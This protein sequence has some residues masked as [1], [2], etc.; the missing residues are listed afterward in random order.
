MSNE[1]ITAKQ[2]VQLAEYLGFKS[3]EVGAKKIPGVEI[4]YKRLDLEEPKEQNVRY[5]IGSLA[6]SSQKVIKSLKQGSRFVVVKK[7]VQNT[8]N[9]SQPYW[10]LEEFRDVSTWVEKPK[11]KKEQ[12]G[13]WDQ[14]GIKVGAARNQAIAFLSATKGKSFTL[15]DVDEVAYEIVARQ[16]KQEEVVRSGNNSYE[17]NATETHTKDVDVYEDTQ[18]DEV[19]F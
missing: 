11:Y 3:V 8:K 19:P 17:I 14:T 10:N 12:G 4:L 6:E 1:P 16:A 7:M 15:D 13:Q 9:P 2:S 18:D 5:L